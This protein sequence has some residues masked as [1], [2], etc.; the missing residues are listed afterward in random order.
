MSAP[1]KAESSLEENL[2][3]EVN[4][5]RR[6]HGRNNLQRNPKLDG[7]ARQHS[8]FLLNN[9]GKSSVFGAKSD[10]S[11]YGFES[12]SFAAQRLYNM[13]QVSENVASAKG[14]G[15]NVASYVVGLWENS[16]SH[17]Y[18]MRTLWT[19]TGVGVAVD[20]DGT[21]FVTEIFA[22]PKVQ[23]HMGM[24]NELRMH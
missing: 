4:A 22:T 14:C 20:D 19:Q 23:S 11:H 3:R 24:V 7:L 1:N 16:Q 5:Y 9:R 8:D 10:I 21:V 12:R 18:N 13:D 6:Q 17:E 15:S 2:Y